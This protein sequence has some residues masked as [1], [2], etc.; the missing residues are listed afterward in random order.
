MND[1]AQQFVA[2]GLPWF[3][4]MTDIPSAYADIESERDCFQK[5]SRA[6]YFAKHLNRE[7]EYHNYRSKTE[8]EAHRIG[9]ASWLAQ[10]P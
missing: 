8:R 6:A 4:R 3:E 2:E 5:F 1:I 7:E 9:R 10:Y